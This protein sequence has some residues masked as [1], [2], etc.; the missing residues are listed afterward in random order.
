MY[1]C[2]CERPMIHFA[3]R[4]LTF[5]SDVAAL[6]WEKHLFLKMMTYNYRVTQTSVDLNIKEGMS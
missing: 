5:L 2:V 1:S 6:G 4:A 3:G